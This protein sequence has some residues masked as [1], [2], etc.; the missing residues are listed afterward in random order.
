[1][2]GGQLQPVGALGATEHFWK[3]QLRASGMMPAV[4][5]AESKRGKFRPVAGPDPDTRGLLG[6]PSLPSGT[7]LASNVPNP[8]GHAKEGVGEGQG[9]GEAGWAISSRG[10]ALEGLCH[11]LPPSHTRHSLTLAVRQRM[12]GTTRLERGSDAR[13]TPIIYTPAISV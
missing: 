13:C 6:G 1:M 7:L 10:G 3:V 5:F 8:T 12:A 2:G 11:G 4:C 9:Q